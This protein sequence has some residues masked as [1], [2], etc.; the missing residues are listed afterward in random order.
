MRQYR[1]LSI[2]V[3]KNIEIQKN[4]IKR[5]KKCKQTKRNTVL[6]RLENSSPPSVA[7][8]LRRL[9]WRKGGA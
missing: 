4:K 5:K 1:T 8:I 3:K 2:Q 6:K 9:I 7:V